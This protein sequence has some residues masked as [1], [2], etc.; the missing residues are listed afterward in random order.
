MQQQMSVE[1]DEVYANK[2]GNK[3]LSFLYQHENEIHN[4]SSDDGQVFHGRKKESEVEMR[5]TFVV[6]SNKNFRFAQERAF[7][8][9]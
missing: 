6:I 4:D 5:K 2:S 7:I 9:L 8:R 3:V 1:E